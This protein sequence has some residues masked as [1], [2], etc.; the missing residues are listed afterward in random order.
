MPLKSQHPLW[1]I[2][3]LIGSLPLPRSKEG[4]NG[5]L[6]NVGQIQ[7]SERESRA[8]DRWRIWPKASEMNYIAE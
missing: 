2:G 7:A 8:R 5:S 6:R 1:Q 4:R 3:G